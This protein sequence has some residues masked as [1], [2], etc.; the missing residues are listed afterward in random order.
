[1]QLRS[2]EYQI[3]RLKHDRLYCMTSHQHDETM[4]ESTLQPAGCRG[5]SLWLGSSTHTTEKTY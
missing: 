3:T 1:M 5:E 2:L 4:T